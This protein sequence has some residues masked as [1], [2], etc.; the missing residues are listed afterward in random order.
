MT[1]G[2]VGGVPLRLHWSF[3]AVVVAW[4]AWTANTA[5]PALVPMAAGGMAA[6]VASVLVHELGHVAMGQRFGIR[7]HEITLLPIGGAARMENRFVSP[8]EDLLVSLAGPGT[9]L[10][11]GG[12][13]LGLGWALESEPI[14]LVAAINGILGLFN[15]VPALPLDGGRVLRAML[16]TNLGKV[17]AQAMALAIGAGFAVLFT[18]GGLQSGELGVT[19][20]GV[21][22]ATLQLQELRIYRLLRERES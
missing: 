15:L 4:L 11:V 7:T 14:L 6:L 5:G 20:T 3:L 2:T 19:V 16:T 18:V 1:I 13:L 21:V 9:S 17:R 22:L 8:V 10:V 12:V